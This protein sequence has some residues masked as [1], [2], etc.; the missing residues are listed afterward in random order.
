MRKYND[1]MTLD[2]QT[3]LGRYGLALTTQTG[4]HIPEGVTD[5]EVHQEPNGM[6]SINCKHRPKIYMLN[7]ALFV[8]TI[9]AVEKKVSYKLF[10]ES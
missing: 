6:W 7:P 10:R 4:G 3:W 2:V 1:L 5:G 8:K 9:V